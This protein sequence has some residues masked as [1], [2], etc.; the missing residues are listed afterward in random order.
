MLKKGTSFVLQNIEILM[1]KEN[2]MNKK[3]SI[4]HFKTKKI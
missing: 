3:K 1:L 4:Y 2:G